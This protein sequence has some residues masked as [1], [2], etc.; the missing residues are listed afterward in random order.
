M[1]PIKS[2]IFSIGK[3]VDLPHS[4]ERFEILRVLIEVFLKNHL[5]AFLRKNMVISE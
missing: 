2:Y 5:E 1:N 4:K 3:T